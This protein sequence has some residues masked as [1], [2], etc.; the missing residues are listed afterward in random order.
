MQCTPRSRREGRKPVTDMTQDMLH[1]SLNSSMGSFDSATSASNFLDQVA[2]A[3][4]ELSHKEWHIHSVGREGLVVPLSPVKK[5]NGRLMPHH[6]VPTA[7]PADDETVF[8]EPDFA[9]EEKSEHPKLYAFA[10]RGDWAGVAMEASLNPRDAKYVDPDSGTTALHLAVMS[11]AIPMQASAGSYQQPASLSVLKLLIVA[12]PEAAIIRCLS[13]RYTPLCYACF[14]TEGYDFKGG[15]EIVRIVL[16]H[17]PHSALVFSDDGYSALDT[18]IIS[19]SRLNQRHRERHHRG[20]GQASTRVLRVLLD[21]HPSLVRPRLYGTSV[22]GPVELLY[23]CNISDFKEA[24]GADLR[25]GSTKGDWWA[26]KWTLEL[27]KASWRLNAAEL[28]GSD[29]VD[30]PF[31]A[32]HAAAQIVACPSPI[33][34]LALEAFPEQVETRCPL[35]QALNSPL[36]EVCGWV[37][38]DWILEGDPFILKRKRCAIEYLLNAFPNAAGIINNLGETP[39]QLAVDTCTPWEQGLRALVKARGAA[40][41][42]PR[43]IEHCTEDGALAK[44]LAFHADD[45]GSVGCNEDEWGEEPLVAVDGMYPFLVASVLACVPERKFRSA[46]LHFE[47]KAALDQRRGLINKDLES[48]RSIYGLLR[49][50]PQALQMFLDDERNRDKSAANMISCSEYDND[51]ESSS[52]CSSTS[53]YYEENDVGT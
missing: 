5:T 51:D 50:R 41:L 45:L 28:G 39:L 38:D 14:V 23:R 19:Y 43:S 6:P 20:R 10:K 42:I 13:K 15:A 17:A 21:E 35:Q 27:L 36:H 47:D 16:E 12:C 4:P 11:R 46:P 25:S 29:A 37:T 9:T 7:P 48:I 53:N 1:Q 40:L 49:S 31:L 2:P 52:C 34:Q 8:S 30:A 26:F 33:L 22:R 44:A 24:S 18:H 3:T 32:L